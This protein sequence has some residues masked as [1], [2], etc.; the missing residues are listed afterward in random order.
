MDDGCADDELAIVLVEP[1]LAD[2]PNSVIV[3]RVEAVGAEH[4]RVRPGNVP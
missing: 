4:D 2:M 3:E 1:E